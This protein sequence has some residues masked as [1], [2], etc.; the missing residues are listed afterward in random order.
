ME[1]IV[2]GVGE[3]EAGESRSLANRQRVVG[4]LRR[5]A[6]CPG[7]ATCRHALKIRGIGD[8]VGAISGGFRAVG[9][10]EGV[11]DDAAGWIDGLRDVSGKVEIV[12]GSF[13]NA[14]C[15]AL[16]DVDAAMIGGVNLIGPGFRARS[17]GSAGALA[18]VLTGRKAEAIG[19]VIG[20]RE[21]G[22]AIG[23]GNFCYAMERVDGAVRRAV[24]RGDAARIGFGNQD[25]VIVVGIGDGADFGIRGG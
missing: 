18:D 5:V 2:V 14:V 10:V 11:V 24:I 17:V 6:N 7:K 20:E 12:R 25:A 4:I 16:I 13:G 9:G 8:A 19:L 22:I 1:A 21:G 23:I 3:V 15:G